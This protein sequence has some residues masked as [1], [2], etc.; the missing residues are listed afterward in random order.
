MDMAILPEL[1]QQ[2][3]MLSFLSRNEVPV[4]RYSQERDSGAITTT[5]FQPTAQQVEQSRLNAL[6]SAEMA[7]WEATGM[8][9]TN[10]V[11]RAINLITHH[12]SRAG[13]REH[14]FGN[15]RPSLTDS[16]T[17]IASN[18][19]RRQ[20]VISIVRDVP[21]NASLVQPVPRS[22]VH[23][24]D[25][26]ARQILLTAASNRARELRMLAP[27]HNYSVLDDLR[28]E[29][30]AL[31]LSE[32]AANSS[33]G[34]LYVSSRQVGPTLEVAECHG[35]CYGAP[36]NVRICVFPVFDEEAAG[37][38]RPLVSRIRVAKTFNKETARNTWSRLCIE[39]HSSVFL[40]P[41]VPTER[42][43]KLNQSQF[44]ISA[45]SGDL[46]LEGSSFHGKSQ[47]VQYKSNSI[48]S[49]AS[50]IYRDP[51][52][53]ILY[54]LTSR[55]WSSDMKRL[56]ARSHCFDDLSS[57]T[58]VDGVQIHPLEEYIRE[59][60]KRGFY[61]IVRRLQRPRKRLTQVE[62]V[63]IGQGLLEWY[64]SNHSAPYP[65]TDEQRLRVVEKVRARAEKPLSKRGIKLMTATTFTSSQATM[66]ALQHA[67]VLA[68][69]I[70][71]KR[72]V[73]SSSGYFELRG[74][75]FASTQGVQAFVYDSM[76]YI[77]GSIHHSTLNSS[78]IMAMTDT[79]N[80]RIIETGDV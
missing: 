5:P 64:T 29:L 56:H 17:R 66:E 19:R 74:I 47:Y 20:S 2:S 75:E 42:M 43:L 62:R 76:S 48:T 80:V 7:R 31:R 46:L 40:C 12:G 33:P 15:R 10:R 57:F 28:L 70:S 65:T 37:R 50:V 18:T 72:T 11:S 16:L 34:A 36:V 49:H 21:S 30:D 63:S 52:T 38:K 24:P 4:I 44:F 35:F 61:F 55:K 58:L 3:R 6:E 69:G 25:I 71:R 54:V 68:A 60:R 78:Y 77:T 59:Q 13:I 51:L 9:R 27:K 22:I 45:N 23:N 8:N 73:L 32:A 26:T 39:T 14:T 41:P 1:Q 53:G 79:D 67:G